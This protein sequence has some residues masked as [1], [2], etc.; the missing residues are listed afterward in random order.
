MQLM[1]DLLSGPAW[2]VL[3]LN[4]LAAVHLGAA[5]FLRSQPLAKWILVAFATSFV[6][7]NLIYAM[8]GYERLLGL[9]HL[10]A[11]P[12]VTVAVVRAL[13]RAALPARWRMYLWA[14]LASQVLSL[15]V[16]LVDVV[17]WFLGNGAL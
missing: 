5:F 16:D 4:W 14:L 15:S 10:L 13:R 8:V 9:A 7:L 1:I 3:W 17:R 2:L 6:L 11:W 12:P